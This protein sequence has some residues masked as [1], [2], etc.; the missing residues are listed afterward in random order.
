MKF[1]LIILLTVSMPLIANV[2]RS[3][4]SCKYRKSLE[5]AKLSSYSD[6]FL[7]DNDSSFQIDKLSG[8]TSI[9]VQV[10]PFRV[11]V[12]D[13]PDEMLIVSISKNPKHVMTF[14][15]L[16][17]TKNVCSDKSI[18]VLNSYSGSRIVNATVYFDHDSNSIYFWGEDRVTQGQIVKS[19]HMI[20]NT[21]YTVDR[22]T[23]KNK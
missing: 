23:G 15:S 11:V 8:A 20:K 17:E 21:I 6:L 9:L 1:T 3:N 16:F 10:E 22:L 2:E 14:S 12:F 4:S 7:G 19:Y 18:D 5:P 13:E